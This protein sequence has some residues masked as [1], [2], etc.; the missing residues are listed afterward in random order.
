MMTMGDAIEA[1]PLIAILRG[2]EPSEA[3]PVADVLVE[4][5]FKIIE[6]PLNSPQPLES[7]EKIAMKHSKNAVVGA[8][9]VLQARDVQAPQADF[10][11]PGRGARAFLRRLR[12]SPRS[13]R[14]LRY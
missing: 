14:A 13:I 11:R 5:G 1:C 4:A 12:R 9:T 10:E 8:G 2:L 7:I 6:V 3:L